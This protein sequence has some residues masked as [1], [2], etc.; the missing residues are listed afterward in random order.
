MKHVFID[1]YLSAA[2][3]FTKIGGLVCTMTTVKKLSKRIPG[4]IIVRKKRLKIPV[5]CNYH[6]DDVLVFYSYGNYKILL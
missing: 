4:S 3:K 1:C 5:A 2:P 6:N